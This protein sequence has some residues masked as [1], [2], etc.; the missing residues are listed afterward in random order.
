MFGTGEAMADQLADPPG[1]AI[2]R[3][4]IERS[5]GLWRVWDARLGRKP[6]RSTSPFGAEAKLATGGAV[7]DPIRPHGAP[8]G[9]KGFGKP[10]TPAMAVKLTDRPWEHGVI[11]WFPVFGQSSAHATRFGA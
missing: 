11:P 3:S 9:K 10:S 7:H 2:K 4:L 1:G 5:K 6:R 8:G